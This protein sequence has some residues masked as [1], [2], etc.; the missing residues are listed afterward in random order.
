M[1]GL[2]DYSSSD[3]DR[4]VDTSN[5]EPP[6][7]RKESKESAMPPLPATFRNLYSTNVRTSTADDPELHGGRRRQVAHVEGNWPSHIYTECKF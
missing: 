1:A 7:A 4:A 3:D 5:V 2:V 6:V